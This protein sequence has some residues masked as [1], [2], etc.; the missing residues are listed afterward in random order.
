M[1]DHQNVSKTWWKI[2]CVLWFHQY[3][4]KFWETQANGTDPFKTQ[5]HIKIREGE[6]LTNEGI[7]LTTIKIGTSIKTQE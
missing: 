4:Y 7:K 6:D 1:K 5:D 3:N 2:E